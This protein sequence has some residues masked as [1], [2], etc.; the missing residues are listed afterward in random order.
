M[1]VFSWSNTAMATLMK[2]SGITCLSGIYLGIT[3]LKQLRRNP[4]QI[5]SVLVIGYKCEQYLLAKTRLSW[6]LLTCFLRCHLLWWK[7]CSV[8]VPDSVLGFSSE[9]SCKGAN[10]GRG[11]SGVDSCPWDHQLVDQPWLGNDHLV[12]DL[13][14]IWTGDLNVEGS[15]CHFW[16]LED[17]ISGFYSK[18]S[19]VQPQTSSSGSVVTIIFSLL[20]W[21]A[22]RFSQHSADLHHF[23]QKES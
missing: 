13:H 20:L 8:S 22:L 19:S 4:A 5:F 21:S 14:W 6:I 15:E 2:E 12:S 18:I 17:W 7:D 9:I 16:S 23:I 3:A 1:V 10:C 11:F